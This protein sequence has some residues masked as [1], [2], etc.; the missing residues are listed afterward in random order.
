MSEAATL[1]LAT[2]ADVPVLEP[3]IRRSVLALQAEDY[4]PEQMDGALGT[5]FG[6][7]SQLIGDG[8]YFAAEHGGCLIGCGGWSKRKT[9]F[10]GDAQPERVDDFLRPGHDAARIR[11][12]FIDPVFARRGFGSLIMR[13][14][15]QAARDAGFVELELVATLT[16]EKLYRRHGFDSYERHEVPLRNGFGLPV[17]KM[18]KSL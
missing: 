16:G 15:E 6:V 10:G 2:L 11:A 12:F 4:S 3:L 18:K 5:V 1:R 9:L 17:I 8:T 13:A 14:C 7:D